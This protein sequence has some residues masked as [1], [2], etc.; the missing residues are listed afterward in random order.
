[1]ALF[2]RVH[3]NYVEEADEARRR[4]AL[5]FMRRITR[6]FMSVATIPRKIYIGYAGERLSIADIVEGKIAADYRFKSRNQLHRLMAGFRIPAFVT[7]CGISVF[8]RGALPH[9]TRALCMRHSLS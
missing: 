9:R 8:G 3:D 5:R 7:G 1:M 6:Q 4:I 2:L